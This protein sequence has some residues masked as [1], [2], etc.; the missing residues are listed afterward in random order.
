MSIYFPSPYRRALTPHFSQ[1][2]FLL[3]P[4]YPFLLCSV[5]YKIPSFFSSCFTAYEIK[6]WMLS[7]PYHSSIFCFPSLS[8]A[9]LLC[10]SFFPFPADRLPFFFPFPSR[11]CRDS[12]SFAAGLQ[13]INSRERV[14]CIHAPRSSPSSFLDLFSLFS[15]LF[16]DKL[17][18]KYF[19][20][21]KNSLSFWAFLSKISPFYEKVLT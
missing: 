5:T 15:L 2:S 7:L 12:R 17:L 19:I 13:I 6:L 9:C 21:R 20:S 4:F 14:Y 11:L 8:S 18:K 16:L 10:L 1:L 3:F